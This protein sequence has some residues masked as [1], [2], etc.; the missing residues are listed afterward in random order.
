[1]YD[2][3]E[4]RI[5]VSKPEEAF[6]ENNLN[7]LTLPNG[8]TSDSIEDLYTGME[9]QC[10]PCLDKIRRSNQKTHIDVMDKVGLFVFLLFLYWRLPRNAVLAEEL[11]KEAFV[12][13]G[14]S[15]FLTVASKSGE[16]LP[17][18]IID[19]WRDSPAFR[20]LF[21]LALPFVPFDRNPEW[22]TTV[23]DWVFLYAGEGTGCAVVGDTPIILKR[24]AQDD[25][26]NPLKQFVFPVARKVVLVSISRR[27][28]YQTPPPEF[29]VDLGLAMIHEAQRFVACPDRKFLQALVRRYKLQL[30]YEKTDTIVPGLFSVLER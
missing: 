26:S 8:D 20:K 29:L 25:P 2:K 11:S 9:H 5:L 21:R 23:N 6:F 1:M 18:E 22:V 10:W 14:E 4:D 3:R 12:K 16:S 30:R 17:D 15:D 24:T 13:D 27:N 19:M 7:T 28:A